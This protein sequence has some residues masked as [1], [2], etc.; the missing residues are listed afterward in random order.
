MQAEAMLKLKLE[1]IQKWTFI[2]KAVLLNEKYSTIEQ[3]SKAN[4]IL[5]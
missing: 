1:T 2:L 5:S 4:L 3:L